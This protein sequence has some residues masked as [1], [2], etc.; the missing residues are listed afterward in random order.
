M[1]STIITKRTKLFCSLSS[2]Y[3]RSTQFSQS[4]VDHNFS[5]N[6]GKLHKLQPNGSNYK[7]MF[8]EY[9]PKWSWKFILFYLLSKSDTFNVRM[10]Q[11]VFLNGQSLASFSFIFGLLKQKIRILQQIIVKNVHSSSGAEI[12][13]HDHLSLLL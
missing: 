2:F 11:I 12:R 7:N 10:F 4:G 8:F 3:Y 5:H 9:A 13:T 1:I 6:L